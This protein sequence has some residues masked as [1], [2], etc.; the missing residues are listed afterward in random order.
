MRIAIRYAL[1]I[2][3]IVSAL[4]KLHDFAATSHLFSQLT[5]AST[6]ATQAALVALIA[7][8]LL[9]AAALVLAGAHS[10]WVD[11]ITFASVGLLTLGSIALLG[12]GGDNCGCFGT[13]A[14]IS[15]AATVVKNLVTLAAAGWLVFGNHPIFPASVVATTLERIA[16][17][18]RAGQ[19]NSS[20]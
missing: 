1:A 10:R 9:L 16:V 12:M 2:L 6:S 13:L 19:A 11:Q 18:A 5:A 20:G 14:V 8:E 15:P 17:I 7:V 4:A 3:F